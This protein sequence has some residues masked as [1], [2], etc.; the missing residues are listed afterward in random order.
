[1]QVKIGEMTQE[2]N[3]GV[4]FVRE[5]DKIAGIDTNG[6]SLGFGL[7]KSLP[8]LKSYDPAV[9][10]DI[11]YSATFKNSPRASRDSVDDFIDGLTE[12]QLEKLFDNVI[13]EVNSANAIKVALKNMQA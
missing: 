4:R 1:M 7:T 2:L 6:V 3:F 10:S 5:L 8:G 11:V 13:K 12:K 9:L